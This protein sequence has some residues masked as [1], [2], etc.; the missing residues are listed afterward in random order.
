[1]KLL[2]LAKQ[3]AE[4]ADVEVSVAVNLYKPTE[5]EALAVKL[6]ERLRR[7]FL[8]DAEAAGVQRD[9]GVALQA[10][11]HMLSQQINNATSAELTYTFEA[12]EAGIA[13]NVLYV[14]DEVIEETGERFA[15]DSS[16][17]PFMRH[18]GEAI[19]AAQRL[20]MLTHGQQVD[21]LDFCA[22]MDKHWA[23]MTAYDEIEGQQEKLIEDA[24]TYLNKARSRLSEAASEDA[25]MFYDCMAF[26]GANGDTLPISVTPNA[27][28]ETVRR[29]ASSYWAFGAE[30]RMFGTFEFQGR[31]SER[32][33]AAAAWNEYGARGLCFKVLAAWIRAFPVEESRGLCAIC[34]RHAATSRRCG[35]HA[36]SD[37]ETRQG[38]LGKHVRPIYLKQINRLVRQSA[39]KS[40]LMA[41]LRPRRKVRTEIMRAIHG[42]RVPGHL[43]DRCAVLADQLH[44]LESLFEPQRSSADARD[45]FRQ[46]VEIASANVTD[47]DCSGLKPRS[48]ADARRQV[49][50]S[51][52]ANELLSLREFLRYWF[53][54]F[55]DL[56]FG[57]QIR[58]RGYDPRHPIIDGSFD[59]LRVA[60]DLLRQR[61]W[62]EA[63]F[64]FTRK[65]MPTPEM[66]RAQLE[67][68]SVRKAAAS[69]KISVRT[70]YKYL[71]PP[72][73][74]RPRNRL[75]IVRHRPHRPR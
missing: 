55:T 19:A 1:M 13:A 73:N 46:I 37:Y 47:P 21:A 75:Q 71:N 23:A 50:L 18:H 59:P 45:L 10:L 49:R 4:I 44:A 22:A 74:E 29:I 57:G 43:V 62:E 35:E 56:D 54:K 24:T 8:K 5:Q 16:Q 30:L 33:K 7:R 28:A 40:S 6:H 70:L 66:I 68:K 27:K 53:G 15:L 36:T 39:V 14:Y 51:D 58:P 9:R 2:E 38:R 65:V 60:Q 72:S 63:L 12:F 41:P 61:A 26:G 48:L 32:R 11:R 31:A 52:R 69:L 34:Y 67:I 25:K 3:I 17:L 20:R 64:S 42:M